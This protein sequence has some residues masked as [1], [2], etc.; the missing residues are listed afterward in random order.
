MGKKAKVKKAAG[1]TA[2]GKNNKLKYINTPPQL[3]G[4]SAQRIARLS[5]RPVRTVNNLIGRLKLIPNGG[6]YP[7]AVV[8]VIRGLKL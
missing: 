3:Q 5:L 4:Y 7:V 2:A 6:L 8:D 1:R